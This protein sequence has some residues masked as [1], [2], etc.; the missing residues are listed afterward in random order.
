MPENNLDP[1]QNALF[2]EIDEELRNDRMKALWKK[3]RFLIAAVIFLAIFSAIAFEA[4]KYWRQQ[5]EAKD[6]TA[7]TGALTLVT[8]GKNDLALSEL[9][10]IAAEK[11]TG[12]AQLAKLE[13]AVLLAKEGKTA[14]VLELLDN[15]RKD[16]RFVKPLRDVAAVAL[17]QRML[18]QEQ[19]DFAKVQEILTPLEN[20]DSAWSAMA[21]SL[22]AVAFLKNKEPEKAK[23]KL[24]LINGNAEL[25]AELRDWARNLAVTLD[26]GA[27]K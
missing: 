6:A 2:R 5:L 18:N 16:N 1:Q 27:K 22:S 13:M 11:N 3:Y 12:Y 9:E 24:Q 19:T 4:F 17:V 10:K 26:N 25:P 8:E 7:Y 20:K 14:E 21:L 15:V 23:E